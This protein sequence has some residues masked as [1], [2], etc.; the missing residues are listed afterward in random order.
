MA[1]EHVAARAGE[2]RCEDERRRWSLDGRGGHSRVRVVTSRNGLSTLKAAPHQVA[3]H[4]FERGKAGSFIDDVGHFYKP[5]QPG[6]R[7]EREESFY[8]YLTSKKRADQMEIRLNEC[9]NHG[10]SWVLQLQRLLGEET[11]F[12]EAVRESLSALGCDLRPSSR[13]RAKRTKRTRHTKTPRKDFRRQ[14]TTRCASSSATRGATPTPR[15]R[16]SGPS[17]PSETYVRAA[18]MPGTPSKRLKRSRALPPR[19]P[20]E[21]EARRK[22]PRSRSNTTRAPAGG[23]WGST[24]N[25]CIVHRC[26]I[27][28]PLLFHFDA[29]A[30]F[31]QRLCA[32]PG[33]PRDENRRQRDD[34]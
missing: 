32:H 26:S 3:G 25:S 14:H 29:P 9:E 22:T 4:L 30:E 12:L 23:S 1:D 15:W 16:V 17:W 13:K 8:A 7:G 2:A 24:C 21:Q 28:V 20:A 6:P 31:T 10:Y 27:I 33:G 34:E 19:Q 11:S 18:K 5:L